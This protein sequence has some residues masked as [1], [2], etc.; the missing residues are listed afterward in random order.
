MPM[1][2]AIN[3][4]TGCGR[5]KDYLEKGGRALLRDF[6][7]LSWD[8]V[9]DK[10]LDEALKDEVEW[11]LE[12]DEL[13]HACH[14]DEPW[15]GR[16]AITFRHYVISPDPGD[17]IDLEGLRELAHAWVK[18]H[19]SDYQVAVIYHDDNRQS[20]PH[21]HIVVNNTNLETGNRLHIPNALDMNRS[22]QEVAK[23]RG[24]TAFDNEMPKGR[25][26]QRDLRTPPRPQ[27]RQAIHVNLPEQG[28]LD[29]GAYSWVSDIRNRVSVA[30]VLSRNEGEFMRILELM[31]IEVAE[32]SPRAP[33]EDWIFSLADQPSKKVSGERLGMTFGKIALAER[34]ERIGSYHPDAATSRAILS[35]ATDA[36][37]I[38]DIAELGKLAKAVETNARYSIGSSADYGK[39]I[40]TLQRRMER[41]PEA[42][43]AAKCAE[44]IQELTEARD[45]TSR[46]SL[47][48]DERPAERPQSP[49][50]DRWQY[51]SQRGGNR[52]Q[53]AAQSSSA[54]RQ[55]DRER[56]QG[57]RSR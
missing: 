17:N 39:R 15:K 53:S 1:L 2:K 29:A 46:H 52:P 55:R 35:M 7:N 18:K 14:N 12:M 25:V 40:E 31:E 50:S 23:A 38:N 8:E 57:G 21:A 54:A 47:V 24:L 30:K 45:Y 6:F 5:I 44:R 26:G 32:N 20:I 37:E 33:R 19:F 16:R 9:E 49:S 13:R 27:T 36:V 42:R 4:H 56:Q 41:E 43:A 34:F 10:G 3:G 28:L 51:K 11:A 22:L 48:P